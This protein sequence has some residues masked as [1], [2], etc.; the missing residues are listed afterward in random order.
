[1]TGSVDRIEEN[2]A[3]IILDDK[4]EKIIDNIYDLKE[5]D[6]VEVYR[7][8]VKKIDNSVSKQ[9]MIDLQNKIFGRGDK[10]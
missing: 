10:N 5:G 4:A 7:N 8:K 9:E 3:V 6:R 1:M 2:K